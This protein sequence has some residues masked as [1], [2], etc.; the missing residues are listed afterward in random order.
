MTDLS[1]E[2]LPFCLPLPSSTAIE[3]V[4]GKGSSLA[5]L[6]AAGFPVPDGFH[7]TTGAYRRFLLVNKIESELIAMARPELV[8]NAVSFDPAAKRIQALFDQCSVSEEIVEAIAG[9]YRRLSGNNLAVAVR[10]SAT[11]EDLP[12]LS[13]AGQQDTY[14]NVTG[15]EALIGSVRNCWASLWTARAMSYRHQMEIGHGRIYMAVVIQR[16]LRAEVSGVLFTANPATGEREELIVN[17]SYGLGEI[18]VSGEVTP[19]AFVLDRASLE[20]KEALIGEKERMVVANS[21]QGTR[22]IAVEQTR[23]EQES[24]SNSQLNALASLALKVEKHFEGLPQDIEWLFAEDN[25]WL[26]QS[27]PITH[28]P[29]VPLKHIRWELPEPRAYLGRSQL[30]E[31]I[32]DPVSTLFEDL[33]MKRSLQHYWGLNL[34]NGGAYSY[35]DTQPPASFVVSTTVNGFAYRHM[36]TP[37]KTGHLR[38]RSKKITWFTSFLGRHVSRRWMYVSFVSEWRYVALPRYLRKV[39]KWRALNPETASVEQLWAGIRAMTKADA[40]YWYRGGA[41]H[42]FSLTR[43]TESQLQNFLQ[44]NAPGRYTTGQF[45]SGLKSF[46]FEAQM[47]LWSIAQ[48]V[49]NEPTL[50]KLAVETAPN[51]LIEIYRDRADATHICEAFDQY[52]DTYGHQVFTLDFVEPSE[53]EDPDSLIRSL[54]GLTLRSDY[55]PRFNQ[56]SLA[57]R[58]RDVAQNA[59]RHFSGT[60]RWKF[61]WRLWVARHYYANREE[62]MFYVGV[63]WTVLRPL[64]IEL[65]Q[66]LTKIGTLGNREAVFFLNTEELARAIRA[67]IHN[68][69][70]PEYQDLTKDRRALR[71]ARR[72]LSPPP[73]IGERPSYWGKEPSSANDGDKKNS[74]ELKGSAVSPGVVTARASLVLSPSDFEKMKPGTVLVCPTTTPAWTHLFPQAKGLV[75]DIGGILAHGSIVA[76]EYGIPA[77]LGLVDVTKRVKHGQLIEVNGDKGT[78]RLVEDG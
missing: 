2:N 55:D 63:A 8:E 53:A 12:D 40:E 14:L 42:A 50:L 71:E 16:L 34:M 26:L 27:R 24:L 66:R 58:R 76:R 5:S 54:H 46:A 30:V 72:Q 61:L 74:D 37:P 36:G 7:V 43:G 25:L 75:T 23:R 57:E 65:G 19:D 47:K 6:S 73:I 4:G 21:D 3:V 33:Y 45:L 1:A 20:R 59:Y 49:R 69:A 77:V 35:E 51:R 31:H 9:A 11:A 22:T 10:S 56:Q 62:A 13:F 44:E 15:D 64:A 60:L 68:V 41:W 70:L 17:A 52:L 48:M 32:P 38:P 78:V 29:V 18:V 39:R 67:A 28:L